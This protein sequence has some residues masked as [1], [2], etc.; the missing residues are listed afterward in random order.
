MSTRLALAAIALGALLVLPGQLGSSA[1]AVELPV[2][3]QHF[4]TAQPCGYED[5][6]HAPR[7][8]DA[9]GKPLYHEG[10]DVIA[11]MGTPI[12]AVVDGTVTRMNNSTRGGNQLRIGLPDGTYFFHAHIRDYAAGLKVG[13]QVHA[14]QVVAYVGQ[15]GDA[16]YSVPHLHFEVHPQ[17]GAAVNPYPI[18]KE[19][20]GCKAG[21]TGRPTGPTP[22]TTAPAK[23]GVTTP[24][25][26]TARP[27][28]TTA[29]RPTSA[30]AP[31]SPA[32]TTTVGSR[33]RTGFTSG[34]GV[35]GDQLPLET[36]ITFGG[37][38]P[39]APR[40]V[41]DSRTGTGLTRLRAGVAQQLPLAGTNT[42]PASAEAVAVNLTATNTGHDG[43]VT[44]WPCGQAAPVASNLTVT[45][46]RTVANAAMSA[47]GSGKLCVQADVDTD[48][49]IDLVGWQ[50]PA[51]AD[52][53]R[54]A[55]ASRLADTRST[56]GR[57]RAGGT[58]EVAV[59]GADLDAAT[60]NV[61]AVTPSAAGYLTV[62]PCGQERPVASTVNYLAGEVVPNVVTARLGSGKLCV[63][64][65]AATDVVV[66]LAGV[67]V[68]SDGARPTA[69]VATRVY[70]T[71][72]AT[73]VSA[74][75]VV[76]VSLGAVVPV[77]A[78]AVQVDVIASGSAA[79]GY[80]T[81]F[82]CDQAQPPTS[83]LNTAPGRSVSNLA[84]VNGARELCVYSS[85]R[86]DIV[87]DVAGYMQ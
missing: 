29:P 77:D 42:V 74:G 23:P 83:N 35:E 28:A 1:Q 72:R 68:A 80:V 40:R 9:N 22:T 73:A 19:V 51:G 55:P 21:S 2:H 61:T 69:I 20:D 8:T 44:T 75:Q 33:P 65:S 71:R 41:A 24:A 54:P 32:P 70:D 46:G 43:S 10:V 85:V 86:T 45:A 79:A 78:A 30:P 27:V 7:G 14:G 18:V 5:S 81:L 50:G 36:P 87:V 26:T 76:H 17:G 15:T 11:P 13:D 62:Y 37:Y 48:L 3:L 57:L 56:F 38:T 47:L 66:D 6:W 31:A 82:P 84:F 16:M 25:V 52:G 63:Y 60:V 53:Y 59:P 67:W 4:P 34:G 39:L 49:V 58:L 64:A 12:L